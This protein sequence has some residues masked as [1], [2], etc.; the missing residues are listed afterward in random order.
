MRIF[1][2]NG[3]DEEILLPI[4]TLLVFLGYANRH[5]FVG[6]PKKRSSIQKADDT[7]K[8]KSHS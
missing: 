6:T 5:L 8:F 1:Q 4:Y 3:S 7:E 2:K